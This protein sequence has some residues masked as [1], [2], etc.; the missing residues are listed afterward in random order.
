MTLFRSSFDEKI[1]AKERSW[2]TDEKGVAKALRDIFSNTYEYSYIGLQKLKSF[3]MRGDVKR[4]D[5]KGYLKSCITLFEWNVI[6]D[7]TISNAIIAVP[8]IEGFDT[9]LYY[10]YSSK[11]RRYEF[12]SAKIQDE[13]AEGS[14]N[15]TEELLYIHK[16]HSKS[17]FPLYINPI[18]WKS[19]HV[20]L[21]RKG[22]PDTIAIRCT[23]T[24]SW[25]ALGRS[26]LPLNQLLRGWL[27]KPNEM[28]SFSTPVF[29]AQ[30]VVSKTGFFSNSM[31]DIGDDIFKDW[32]MWSF[33]HRTLNQIM[34]PKWGFE[35]YNPSWVNW[36]IPLTPVGI[37]EVCQLLNLAHADLVS[38]RKHR[39]SPKKFKS[40]PIPN[41]YPVSGITL[42]ANNHIVSRLM[43]LNGL[44]DRVDIK[45]KEYS[46]SESLLVRASIPVGLMSRLGVN[47]NH[48][49]DSVS[50]LHSGM[51]KGNDIDEDLS[52]D[53]K[54][55]N[56]NAVK[57][58]ELLKSQ[59]HKAIENYLNQDQ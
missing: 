43:K 13:R 47:K 14:I 26:K 24:V 16:I 30:E 54:P 31:K 19:D 46:L 33:T 42:R 44:P 51:L 35:V 15:V 37:S 29:L 28:M 53:L 3:S 36:S 39:K 40:K 38:G 17:P 56:P 34:L 4:S 5:V 59:I 7:P 21:D 2:V 48:A 11:S 20:L 10:K 50:G 8:K 6:T 23:F 27:Q 12:S 41:S 25:E 22:N 45:L 9:T 57:E 1:E 58:V 49:I 55:E 52:R 32:S 18:D